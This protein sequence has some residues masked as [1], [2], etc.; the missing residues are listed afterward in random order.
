MTGTPAGV[1]EIVAG[2]VFEGRVVDK[3]TVLVTKQWQA[4]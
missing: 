3:D 1:G 4:I 2:D